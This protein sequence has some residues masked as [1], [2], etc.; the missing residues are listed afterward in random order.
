MPL[1]ILHRSFPDE[2]RKTVKSDPERIKEGNKEIEGMG[3]ID[4]F[5]KTLK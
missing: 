1:C 4:Q 3:A 2:G 5:I